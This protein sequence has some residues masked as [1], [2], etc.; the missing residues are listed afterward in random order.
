MARA[1]AL[2]EATRTSL[3]ALAA[4]L[5]ELCQARQLREEEVR[6]GG[7]GWHGFAWHG[8]GVG[9]GRRMPTS[10]VGVGWHA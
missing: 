10:C 3:P 6:R 5:R 1:K 9:P 4:A 7:G 8:M 2:A